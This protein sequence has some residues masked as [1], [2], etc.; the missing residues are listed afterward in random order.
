VPAGLILTVT[1]LTGEA[2][3]AK[4]KYTVF[5]GSDPDTVSP[6]GRLPTNCNVFGAPEVS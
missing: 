2:L 3:D 6:L 4:G 5:G 1:S